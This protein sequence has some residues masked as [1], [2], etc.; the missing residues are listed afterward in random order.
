VIIAPIGPSGIAFLG[1]EGKV[2]STGKQRIADIHESGENLQVTWQVRRRVVT[3]HGF[4]DTPPA[5]SIADGKP[6]PGSIRSRD[7]H[8]TVAIHMPPAAAGNSSASAAQ[9]AG[10]TLLSRNGGGVATSG[11]NW[12]AEIARGER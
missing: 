9:T 3:L 10:K 7:Q 4:A 2:A 11:C 5:C 1:D 12:W 6:L 8:F